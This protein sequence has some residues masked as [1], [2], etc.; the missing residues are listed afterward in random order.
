MED[1]VMD[2]IAFYLSEFDSMVIFNLPRAEM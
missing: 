2:I 1:R